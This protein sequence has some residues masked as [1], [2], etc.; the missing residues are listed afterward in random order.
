MKV[1]ICVGICFRACKAFQEPNWEVIKEVHFKEPLQRVSAM[2]SEV[3]ALGID[4]L[5]K[6]LVKWDECLVD[7]K[8]FFKANRHYKQTNY[9]EE[10]L[11]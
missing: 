1:D 10:R 3:R 2:L 5:E 6:E 7:V 9:K 11:A 8:R 4:N